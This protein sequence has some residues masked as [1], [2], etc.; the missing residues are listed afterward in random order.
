MRR[1]THS[2]ELTT[3]LGHTQFRGYAEYSAKDASLNTDVVFLDR[4][5]LVFFKVI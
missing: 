3:D 2:V 4:F 5:G 1:A